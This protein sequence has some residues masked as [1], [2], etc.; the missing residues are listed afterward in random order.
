MRPGSAALSPQ[1]RAPRV[2]VTTPVRLLWRDRAGVRRGTLATMRN[3]SPSGALVTCTGE[4]PIPPFRLVELQA[5]ALDARSHVRSHD[6]APIRA[7]IWRV[8]RPA[9]G[10]TD[11]AYALRFLVDPAAVIDHVTLAV[12]S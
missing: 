12:A 3:V 9:G 8:E 2:P 6:D 7:V 10:R 1:P 4:R 5:G 11:T